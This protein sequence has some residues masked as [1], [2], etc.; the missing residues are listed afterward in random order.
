MINTKPNRDHQYKLRSCLN[1]NSFI[2]MSCIAYREH[3]QPVMWCDKAKYG[4]LKY[5]GKHIK[6][7]SKAEK[8]K[9]KK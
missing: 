4:C 6:E 7:L 2:D 5:Q 8:R 9:L 1:C 3:Q